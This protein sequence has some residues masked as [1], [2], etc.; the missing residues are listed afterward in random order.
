MADISTKVLNIISQVLHK[1]VDELEM[2]TLFADQAIDEFDVI[3]M[4]MKLEDHFGII[5]QD[6]QVA[7]FSSLQ[8]I[9]DH[10]SDLVE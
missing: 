9:I 1:A 4:I 3:E 2:D 7:E 5:M 8:D 6:A 10:V